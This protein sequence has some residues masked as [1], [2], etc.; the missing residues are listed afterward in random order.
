[1]QKKTNI[2]LC[3]AMQGTNDNG[4]SWREEVLGRIE[5]DFAT[6]L[7]AFSPRI[8]GLDN[9]SPTERFTE[10][11]KRT[12]RFLNMMRNGIEEDLQY[13]SMKADYVLAYID[14]NF[15]RS[16]GSNA[17]ITWAFMADVPVLAVLAPDMSI[18][19]IRAW[20]SG[21]FFR[22]FNTIDDA[23][24]YAYFWSNQKDIQSYG[25]QPA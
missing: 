11:R 6:T 5:R 23:L 2:Y 17:E 25:R 7:E 3:G 12:P 1:M 20:A 4:Q 15:E 13:I 8:L 21:C 22:V 18:D 24:A 14:E 9:L 10:A 16:A 19:K